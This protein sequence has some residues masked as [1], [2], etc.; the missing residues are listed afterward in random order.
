MI[1]LLKDDFCQLVTDN[2]KILYLNHNEPLEISVVKGPEVRCQKG[3]TKDVLV[4]R[5]EIL[6]LGIIFPEPVFLGINT[7]TQVFSKNLDILGIF[8][9]FV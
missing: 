3:L 2:D 8:V 7:H 1:I 5:F 4:S 6:F 9:K